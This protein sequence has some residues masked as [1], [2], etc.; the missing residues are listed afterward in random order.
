VRLIGYSGLDMTAFWERA[1]ELQIEVD[2]K[3]V[4]FL[5]D[6]RPSY[7]N[8]EVLMAVYDLTRMDKREGNPP[9]YELNAEAR[10][11]V[12]QLLGPAPEHPLA[13]FIRHGPVDI[14]GEENAL[15]KT[16]YEIRWK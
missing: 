15:Q 5:G 2:G 4:P 1:K 16:V 8:H 12:S 7:T 3:P 13:D 10:Q 6:Q 14:M 11:A 9:R